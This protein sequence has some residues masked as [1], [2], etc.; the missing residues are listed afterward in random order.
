[1]LTDLQK[2]SIQAIVNIFETGR[3]LGDYG[4]VTLLTGDSGHLTY[5]RS[6]T[7]LASGNLYLLIKDY[8]AAPGA[9]RA[10]RLSPFLERL[11]DIDLALDRDRT[12]RALLEEAGGDPVMQSVQERR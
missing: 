7:T 11:E 3:A 10:D 9:A 5:G 8:C 6:Q 4:Q 1:M 12:F 2:R